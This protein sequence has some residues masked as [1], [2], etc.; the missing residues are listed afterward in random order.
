MVIKSVDNHIVV[1]FFFFSRRRITDPDLSGLL[2]HWAGPASDPLLLRSSTL[3]LP[4]GGGARLN[5]ARRPRHRR[6]A[7]DTKLA[8]ASSF[9]RDEGYTVSDCVEKLCSYVAFFPSNR[10]SIHNIRPAL[11]L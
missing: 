5:H 3:P 6:H 1:V 11:S 9:L 8:T 2:S 10:R 4:A 7:S